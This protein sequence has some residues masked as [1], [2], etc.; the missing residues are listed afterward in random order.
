MEA[1]DG[2]SQSEVCASTVFHSIVCLLLCDS[3]AMGCTDQR[4]LSVRIA[5]TPSRFPL[6]L[7]NIQLS[8]WK[9]RME[10]HCR[11]VRLSLMPQPAPSWV[12]ANM[13]SGLD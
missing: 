6:V 10:N 11:I 7:L 13:I 4:I 1:C 12:R 2:L 3:A 8:S 9:M 5:L